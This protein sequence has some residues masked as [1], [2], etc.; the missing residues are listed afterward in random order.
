MDDQHE[1]YHCGSAWLINFQLY[2]A[3]ISQHSTAE[4][5]GDIPTVLVIVREEMA[6]FSYGCDTLWLTFLSEWLDLVLHHRISICLRELFATTIGRTI[7]IFTTATFFK[8]F[9]FYLKVSS[10]RGE[11][12]PLLSPRNNLFASVADLNEDGYAR[13]TQDQPYKLRIAQ[14]IMR[15][16]GS[17]DLI[18]FSAPVFT[19]VISPGGRHIIG[20]HNRTMD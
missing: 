10:P 1:Q 2:P 16:F 3:I 7:S 17:V 15:P 8:S 4:K 20:H 13:R 9:F 6:R 19:L 18:A 11:L 14:L 12:S 5:A